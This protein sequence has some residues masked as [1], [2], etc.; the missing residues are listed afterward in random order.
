MVSNELRLK[1]RER[2][3]QELQVPRRLQKGHVL[4]LLAKGLF[5]RVIPRFRGVAEDVKGG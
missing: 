2:G 5:P 4:E 1:S 3:T